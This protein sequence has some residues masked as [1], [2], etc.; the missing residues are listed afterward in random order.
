VVSSSRGSTSALISSEIDMLDLVTIDA[1]AV[2][3][4]PRRCA[5]LAAGTPKKWIDQTRLGV[6][7]VVRLH[8]S[9]IVEP[10][11]EARGEG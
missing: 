10:R 1:A 3:V 4:S 8:K 6:V 2:F 11:C 5:C 9:W 7:R